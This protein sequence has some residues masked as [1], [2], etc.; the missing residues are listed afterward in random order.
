MI[1]CKSDNGNAFFV[2]LEWLATIFM[3]EC[4]VPVRKCLRFGKQ[5]IEFLIT[6]LCLY[7]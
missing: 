7:I 2:L 3:G 1:L 5:T 6:S 4:P